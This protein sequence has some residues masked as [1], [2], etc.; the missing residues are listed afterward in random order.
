MATVVGKLTPHR[1]A[2]PDPLK[3]LLQKYPA[4]TLFHDGPVRHRLPDR[5]A[6]RKP[7]ALVALKLG[8]DNA[9]RFLTGSKARTKSGLKAAVSKL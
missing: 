1:K 3:V 9:V 5:Q 4:L 2:Q 6:N 8:D 7:L